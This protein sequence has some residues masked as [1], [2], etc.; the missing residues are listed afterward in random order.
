MS[1]A[2]EMKAKAKAQYDANFKKE[3]ELK[4]EMVL[5]KIRESSSRGETILRIPPSDIYLFKTLQHKTGDEVRNRLI[6]NGF[7]IGE[8]LCPI[9]WVV[10]WGD[11]IN[12][13][14]T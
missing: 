11:E 3:V 14:E 10:D 8:E 1:L 13:D 5:R 4:Y 9:A 7:R 12:Y 6:E 2:D